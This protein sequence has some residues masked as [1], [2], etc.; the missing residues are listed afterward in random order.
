MRVQRVTPFLRTALLLLGAAAFVPA[1]HAQTPA[2]LAEAIRFREI[3]PTRQGGR[4]VDFAVVES[5]PQ[6]FYAATGS[7]GLWKTVNNG[8]SFEPVFDNEHTISIGAVAVSQSNPDVV[9]V[10]TGEGNNSRSVYYGD[11]VY[12]STDGGKTWK[13]V[14]L[15]N[16]G[17]IG[18][19][20][21]HP[22]NPNVVVV[23]ALGHLYG[24]NPDRGVYRSADGGATWTKTLDYKVDG[25]AIGA[26][27]VQM[28]P[29]NPQVLYAATYDKVRH[30]WSFG[31]GGQGSRLFKSTDGGATWQ[32]LT[33]GLSTGLLGRIGISI[34]RSDPKTVYAVIENVN[35]LTM[36]EAQRK[37]CLA[38][39]YGDNSIGD[40]LFRSDDAGK[41]WRKVA[42]NASA[43]AAPQGEDSS[44]TATGGACGGRGGRGA[45]AVAPPAGGAAGR[46][47][48]DTAA[49]GGRGGRGGRG[50][51]AGGRGAGGAG[52]ADT[53]AGARGAGGGGGRGATF[54]AN[55]PYYY[56]Q[57]RVDPKNKEHIYLLSV[58]VT[59]SI[60]GGKV[61]TSPFNFGGDNHALWIDPKDPDH[62]L[63]G[64][65]HG[66]GVTFD[67]GKNWLHPDN[68][69]TAQFYSIAY[70]NDHPYNVYGGLQDNGSKKGPS[71]RR[72]GGNIPFEAWYNTGGGDGMYNVVDWK[73]SRWLYNESQFGP[74]QR[75]DQL[76]GESKS[77]RYARPAGDARPPLRWNWAA[78]ILVSPHNSDV[79]YH[80]ANVLLRSSFRGENWTEISP[81]LTVNAEDRRGGTGNIQY[82]TIST[83]DESPIVA[84]ELWVGTDD[85]NVQMTRNGGATWTN[86][87]EKIPGF[88]A[89][90]WVSRVAASH[91]DAGVAYVAVSG[92]R[93]D[94][95]KPYLWKTTD[96]GATWTS[97][98]G[99]LPNEDVNVIREDH[100]NPNLLFVGTDLGLYVS[101]DGGKSYTKL[102]GGLPTN[103]IHDLQIHARENELIVATHGRGV[104]IA[105]I[106]ALQGLDAQT[107]AADAALFDIQTTVQWANVPQPQFASLNYGGQS[108]PAGVF[109]NY[110]LKNAVSGGV[111][112]RVLDGA[113][114]IAEV[115]GP[116]GAGLQTV[117]WNMQARRDVAPEEQ[118][119]RGGG[120]GGRGG[121]GGGFG[122]RGGGRGGANGGIVFP[123]AGAGNVSLTT[124]TPGVY[125]VVLKAGNTEISKNAVILE[126]SWAQK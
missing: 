68:L 45:G 51:A 72:G 47:A 1:A 113:R 73:D 34:A 124:V 119:G 8:I 27:D 83:I 114:V 43:P 120:R 82:A 10:G 4:F 74:L 118:A 110:Y 95:F 37:A 40:E 66:M 46:G 49:A 32:M 12:K 48:A 87:R 5:K 122:G 39:G 117:R 20:V 94:D 105:D 84:G 22:T 71:S 21:V 112:V 44:A 6:I 17:H 100:K 111:N 13:N 24:E 59:H 88:P 56:G 19:I 29:S 86:V 80:A 31:E 25:R 7:G 67:G 102:H 91:Y 123:A 38:L 116:G 107:M 62:M 78:P 36:P 89:G 121:G 70:D 99:N 52:A 23:A 104:W 55:P 9:Y 28:D 98:A 96:F 106:T 93:N 42:P 90:Y 97:I 58:G 103:P 61:W 50:G 77:I 11:G 14:G 64:Y 53:T 15:P 54:G 57:I 33:N 60:D 76:T 16:S 3:G 2:N 65:D 41:T 109:I 115:T 85:G 92:Y 75:V 81:D 63:L 126:D 30:A 125:T 18:R 108:R 26:V 79:I 69:P 35:S 101:L